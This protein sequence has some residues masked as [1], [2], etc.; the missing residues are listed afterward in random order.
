V[1]WL[2]ELGE[3]AAREAGR[4]LTARYRL[5]APEASRDLGLENLENLILGRAAPAQTEVDTADTEAP[6]G[7]FQFSS[8]G[9]PISVPLPGAA[10]DAVGA[11]GGVAIGTVTHNSADP[12]PGS[13]LVVG[14]LRP[15]L[16]PVLPRLAGLVAETGNP[17]A[18]LAILAREAGVA[19]VVRVGD[20]RSRFAEGDEVEVDGVSGQIELLGA[21][22]RGTTT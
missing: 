12:P 1:R 4:R 13:V 11:G 20:A 22:T 15:E 2:N 18:H 7:T 5:D 3:R 8:G 19:T 16:A 10:A 14:R 21:A 9:L 17:L 6:A